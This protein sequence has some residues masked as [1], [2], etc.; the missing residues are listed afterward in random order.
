MTLATPGIVLR[1]TPYSDSTVIVRAFTRQLGVRSYLARGV[2]GPRGRS[3]QHLLQPLASLDIVVSHN[4]R[5]EM[6]HINDLT[7]RH[8]DQPSDPALG[9]LRLFAAEVLYRTLP[10]ADPMPDLYDYIEATTTGP[11]P[12][13]PDYPITFLLTLAHYLG[14]G[15]LDNHTPRTPHFDLQQGCYVASPTAT[16]LPPHLSAM[17][18]DYLASADRHQYPSD[19]RRALLDALLTYYRL[20]LPTFH[21]LHSHEILHTALR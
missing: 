10:D 14:I 3:R 20:H 19:D 16:T 2:R 5:R 15:P 8:P 1:T 9:A 17:L 11:T 18:H 21:Q 4:P 13:P 6:G 12:L 7:A